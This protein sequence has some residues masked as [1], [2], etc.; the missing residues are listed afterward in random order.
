VRLLTGGAHVVVL[1]DFSTGSAD[2]LADARGLGED[3]IARC[4]VRT[5]ACADLI[6]ARRPACEDHS[7]APNTLYG[8]SKTAALHYVVDRRSGR[9]Y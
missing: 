2:N 7:H 9:G 3:S 6:T 5:P 1:D 8:L 4:D